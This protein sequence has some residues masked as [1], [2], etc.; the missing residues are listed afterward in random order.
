MVH[1][2]L[3]EDFTHPFKTDKNG[4]E[5]ESRETQLLGLTGLLLLVLGRFSRLAQL[6]APAARS[7]H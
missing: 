5:F 7:K 3:N 6:A 4:D 2:R 1:Y